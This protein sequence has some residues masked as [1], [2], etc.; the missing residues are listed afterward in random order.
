MYPNPITLFTGLHGFLLVIKIF[1]VAAMIYLA[2]KNR[3]ALISSIETSP[4]RERMTRQQIMKFSLIEIGLG[5]AI[6]SLTAIV[7]GVSP[8]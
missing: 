3:T 8:T 7:V 6:L 5:T 2:A 1:V 4:R